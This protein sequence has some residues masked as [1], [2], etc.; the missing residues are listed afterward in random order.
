MVRNN[1]SVAGGGRRR[2]AD[3]AWAIKPAR[4]ACSFSTEAKYRKEFISDAVFIPHDPGDVVV[5][6][7]L[8]LMF[9]APTPPPMPQRRAARI[10]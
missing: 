1:D 3:R 8:N 10:P 5:S 7:G 4:R 9:G 2:R 6:V